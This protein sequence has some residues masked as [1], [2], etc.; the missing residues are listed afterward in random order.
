MV[1]PAPVV[2][3]VRGVERDELKSAA[4]AR[5]R[6]RGYAGMADFWKRGLIAVRENP[7]FV[8]FMGELAFSKFL[9]DRLGEVYDVDVTL[10]K[11]GDGGRDFFVR[12]VRV[13][14]KTAFTA[15]DDL[16]V[17][18]QLSTGELVDLEWDVCVRGAWPCRV[19]DCRQRALS[20]LFSSTPDYSP[21]R[22]C[23]AL[24]GWTTREHLLSAGPP[25]PAKRGDH[26][27]LCL[28]PHMFLPM[29]R[30]LDHLCGFGGN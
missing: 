18:R 20:G 6:F 8:G 19:C 16:L 15:Y 10:R 5:D 7:T 3:P 28:R 26:Y 27:N 23:V 9:R 29:S 24:L 12:G 2:V 11:N 1:R 22:D 17:R 25:E 13:Q 30:L 21:C 14:M 4:D